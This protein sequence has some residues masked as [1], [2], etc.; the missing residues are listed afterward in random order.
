MD[1]RR[2]T[3]LKTALWTL[4]CAAASGVLAVLLDN[5]DVMIRVMYTTISMTVCAGIILPLS[6]ML[7]RTRTRL[8]G[9]FGI[10]AAV[11][12]FLTV[13]ALIWVTD[14]PGYSNLEEELLVSVLSFGFAAS[15]TVGM[16]VLARTDRTRLA[17]WYGIVGMAGFTVMMWVATWVPWTWEEENGAFITGWWLAYAGSVCL[18][19]LVGFRRGPDPHLWRWAGV[20]IT[21]I[22]LPLFIAD[23]WRPCIIN[24]WLYGSG[25]T[26]PV[27]VCYSN[28]L[29]LI[30]S[31][32]GT[33]WAH[34]VSIAA[35]AFTVVVINILVITNF[36]WYEDLLFK[37]ISAGS[38]VTGCGTLAVAVLQALFRR[39]GE[40]STDTALLITVSLTCPRCALTQEVTVGKGRYAACGLR[41]RLSI[42]EP[43]CPDCGYLLHRHAS[44]RC[45]ECG[46]II[47]QTD[48]AAIPADRQ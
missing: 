27:L 36:E 25:V 26:L 38:I 19:C 16:L 33:R 4:G 17:A 30:P 29:L 12:E 48:D 34:Y 2:K 47:R 41:I 31:K 23:A 35:A 8:A 45:P 13:L 46:L 43:R 7:E 6:L 42:D 37:L 5:D 32:P 44:A 9:M 28:M 10:A 3:I 21:L 18:G 1:R 24:V 40:I 15:A 11:F 22:C 20:A 39:T 14:M